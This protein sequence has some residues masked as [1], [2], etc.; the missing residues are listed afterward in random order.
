MSANAVGSTPYSAGGRP[1]TA[2]SPMLGSSA[3]WK[4]HTSVPL[5][6]VT[7]F[8]ASSTY[9]DGRWSRHMS[10]GSTT[11]SSTETRIRSSSCMPVPPAGSGV[12]AEDAHRVAG[13]DPVALVC[14]HVG[15][16][17]VDRLP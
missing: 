6:L 5:S 15:H 3:P 7:S 16:R 1:A 9:F 14:G 13:D 8:G 4:D 17:V 11:W 10:G 12:Q 2:F